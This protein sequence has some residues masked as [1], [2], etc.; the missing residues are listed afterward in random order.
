MGTYVVEKSFA[1]HVSISPNVI[2][3]AKM[4]GLGTEQDKPIQVLQRR[5]ITIE[6]GQVV[7]LTGASGA[8]KS[9]LLKELQDNFPDAL[10]LNEYEL[11]EG[12]P[13]VD[14]FADG[15]DDSF[16]WLGMAGLSDAYVLLRTAEQ[17]SDGQRYRLRLALAMADKPKAIFIDEF[18]AALDRITAAVIAHNVRRYADQYGTTFVLA[19]SHDDL[20]EDLQPDVVV[21][22]HLGSSWDVMYPGR[23]RADSG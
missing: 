22:K 13:I 11:S 20:I 14:C 10:D 15:L 16:L 4:F 17:L 9:V 1:S 18:C 19:T 21:V 2:S 5:E 8:G 3:I 6:S 12:V 23:M 7:Y